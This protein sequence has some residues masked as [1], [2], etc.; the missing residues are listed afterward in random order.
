[1]FS[2]LLILTEEDSTRVPDAQRCFDTHPT[3]KLGRGEIN[4]QFVHTLIFG[5]KI[6][7]DE[8]ILT[9]M[10]SIYSYERDHRIKEFKCTNQ[11]HANTVTKIK[12]TRISQPLNIF[13]IISKGDET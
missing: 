2:E 6:E 1:M 4:S 8:N 11:R 9:H 3:V 5:P 12:R 7:M 13:E 10:G